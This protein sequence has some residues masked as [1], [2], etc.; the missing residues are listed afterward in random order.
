MDRERVKLLFDDLPQLLICDRLMK[1]HLVELDMR[2]DL[3]LVDGKIGQHLQRVFDLR[4]RNLFLGP[5]AL[6][7]PRLVV[8]LVVDLG[9]RHDYVAKHVAVQIGVV[10]LHDMPHVLDLANDRHDAQVEEL[11]VRVVDEV[12]RLEVLVAD[13]DVGDA[14]KF[15]VDSVQDEVGSKRSRIDPLVLQIEV[16]LVPDL[17]NKIHVA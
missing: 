11:Q 1:V 3:L 14:H 2:H 7:I 9:A 5:G 15:T 6:H 4:V 8:Q 10:V 13:Y 12:R 16:L 17:V